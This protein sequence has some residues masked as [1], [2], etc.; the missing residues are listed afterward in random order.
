MVGPVASRLSPLASKAPCGVILVVA[1]LLGCESASRQYAPPKLGALLATPDPLSLGELD[2]GRTAD[3]VLVLKNAFDQPVTVTSVATS[4]PCL[5]TSPPSFR[6]EAHD[7]RELKVTFDSAEE[8]DFRGGLSI[9]VTGSD[10]SGK[11]VFRGRVNLT[12]LAAPGR[13]DR[14]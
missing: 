7:Q 11:T 2:A 13:E 4:C 8:P 3:G 9:D 14:R 5:T 10:A 12:V 1:P 6:I